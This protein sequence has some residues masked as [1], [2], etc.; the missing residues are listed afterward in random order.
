LVQAFRRIKSDAVLV[1]AGD[2]GMRS[3][4]EELALEH[5]LSDHV[6]F[7]GY[8]PPDETLAYYAMAHAFVLPSITTKCGKEPW[9]LVVNEAMNQGVPVIVTESV[10]AAAGGLV[11]DRVN[12]FVVPERNAAAMAGAMME[13]LESA[14]LREEMGENARR[15]IS[16]WDNGEMVRGFE[17]AVAYALRKSD[18]V[19]TPR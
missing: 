10:G 13:L 1:I 7:A 19:L 14:K 9:G 17:R 18:P 16:T 15:I 12:G 4:L 3:A 2:G 6:R 5:G 11:R 8:V